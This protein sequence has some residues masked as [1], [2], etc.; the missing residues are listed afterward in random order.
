MDGET[1][2]TPYIP[3]ATGIENSDDPSVET[4]SDGCGERENNN[5]LLLSGCIHLGLNA[6]NCINLRIIPRLIQT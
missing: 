4:S 2:N 3:S 5:T 6:H 1:D